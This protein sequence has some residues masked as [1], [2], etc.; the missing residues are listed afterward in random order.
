MARGTITLGVLTTMMGLAGTAEAA[1]P[2]YYADQMT[3]QAELSVS[4]T[5][6][7]SNPGYVFAQNNVTMSGVIGETDYVTTGHMN[8]NLVFNAPA[9][10]RYCAG[11]NGSFELSF[12]TTSVG[13]PTGVN[14]VGLFIETH[15]LGTQYYAFISF[16]DGTTDN[17]ALPAGGTFWGV[18]APEQIESIHFGLSMGASTTG[19]SFS[20]DDLIVGSGNVAGCMLDA[21]CFEDGDPC[22]DQVCNMGL[23]EFPFNAAPC[24]DGDVCTDMDVCN[25]GVCGGS[26]LDCDDGNP[27][28][29]ELC[30]PAAGCINQ[31]NSDPCDDGDLC[32]EVD[33]CSMGMCVGTSLDCSDGDVCSMDSC[34]PMMGCINEPIA[35][36][37]VGDEDCG[38]E[39]T[40]DQDMNVCVPGSSGSTGP[41]DDTGPGDTS[42]G[43]TGADGTDGGDS[44][45]AETGVGV[46]GGLETG[47]DDSGSGGTTG[48]AEIPP[49]DFSACDCTTQPDPGHERLWWLMVV[50]GV[51]ARR[52]RDRQG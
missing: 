32:T 10:P 51:F 39:E 20:I 13:T 52:R 12:L 25:A 7:Y 30:D 18:T 48:P 29:D 17:V 38:E 11:C 27:C 8:N 16:A 37:C 6:D 36:C 3:F 14:G 45:V 21:D 47:G 40:C 35:S 34:D 4:V 50:L 23:C 5:D 46:T 26:P 43:E 1:S 19:G 2:T 42:A 44:G 9:D 31:L 22:T 15:N 49:P 33:T 28:T 41:S 24:D